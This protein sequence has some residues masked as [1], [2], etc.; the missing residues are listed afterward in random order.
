MTGGGDWAFPGAGP[1][2]GVAGDG[3][4]WGVREARPALKAVPERA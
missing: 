2:R 3:R 1:R 4:C